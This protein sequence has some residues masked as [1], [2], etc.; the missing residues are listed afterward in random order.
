MVEFLGKRRNC[1]RLSSAMKRFFEIKGDFNLRD[2][3][4]VGC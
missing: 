3:P 2:L 4:P 1:T